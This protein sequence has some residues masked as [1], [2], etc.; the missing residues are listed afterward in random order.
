MGFYPFTSSASGGAQ[1]WQFFVDNYGTKGD[2]QLG[3]CSVVNGSGVVTLTTG[4][5]RPS[6]VGKNICIGGG[7]IAPPSAPTVDTIASVNV[8]ANTFTLATLTAAAT[9]A[10]L[11]V[12]WSSDDRAAIN[13]AVAAAAAYALSTGNYM[14]EVVF[15]NKIYGVGTGLFQQQGSGLFTYN[16]QIPIPTPARSGATQKLEIRFTGPGIGS[17]EQYWESTIPNLAGAAIMSYTSGPTSPDPTF[18]QQS[19]FGGPT[20][21]LL[22]GQYANVKPYFRGIQAWQPGWSNSIAF[23]MIW[24]GGMTI[25]GAGAFGFAPSAVSGGAPNPYSGWVGNA[26]WQGKN[27]VGFRLPAIGNNQDQLVLAASVGGLNLG[28]SVNDGFNAHLLRAVSCD[29]A[30]KQDS[31]LGLGGDGHDLVIDRLYWE[32]CNACIIGGG[33]GLTYGLYVNLDAENTAIT[34]NDISDP[35]NGFRG[36]VHWMDTFRTV[37]SPTINGAAALKII[38][39]M[40]GPGHMASPPAVPATTVAATLVYRDAMVKITTGAGV[41]VS[42]VTVDGTATGQTVAAASTLYPVRV[43]SGKT[44]ALTYAGGTPTWDW[45]LD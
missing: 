30:L 24:C 40:I 41:T 34:H 38:N 4:T 35:S 20:G 17:H 45:W 5:V 21:G 29:V 33:A 7:Q 9:T 32:N 25:D 44:I 26:F 14:A 22:A 43:P 42:A 15:G 12:V 2:G 27:A 23:D 28:Y 6:D 10:G 11:P 1:P 8:G 19:I 3:I 13:N 31:S 39:D 18:G 37:P 16:A 36:V